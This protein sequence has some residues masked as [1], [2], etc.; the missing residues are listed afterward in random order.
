MSTTPRPRNNNWLAS[1]IVGVLWSCASLLIST[2]V[3]QSRL[4]PVVLAA[5]GQS[6]GRSIWDGVYQDEQRR[7]GAQLGKSTCAQCHGDSLGGDSAPPLS[8]PDFLAAWTGKSLGD[9]YEKIQTTMPADAPGTL[10][11]QQS[12]DLLAYILYLNEVPASD[13]RLEVDRPALNQIQIRG[14]R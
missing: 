12:I 9:L 13:S 1:I 7:T 2:I 11:P 8:G 6:N 10:K 4:E 3:S 5:A 14:K